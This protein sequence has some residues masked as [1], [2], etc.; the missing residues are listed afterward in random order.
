MGFYDVHDRVVGIFQGPVALPFGI[1][2]KARSP[3]WRRLIIGF[4]ALSWASLADV[5]AQVL[6]DVT[7]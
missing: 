3:A 5:A 4:M 7:S 1:T 6:N 2:E